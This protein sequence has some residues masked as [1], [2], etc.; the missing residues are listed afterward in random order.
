MISFVARRPIAFSI[1]AVLSPLIAIKLLDAWLTSLA[2][3]D[4]GNRLVVE[5]LFC[6]YVTFLLSRLHWWHDAGFR[7]P[8]VRSRLLAYLPLLFLPLIVLAGAGIKPASGNRIIGFAIFTLM[9]GFA[10]EGL[11][12]GVVL[13]ALL[14][15][16]AMRAALISSLIFG[17]GHLANIWQGASPSATV[18]QVIFST[19]LGIGFAGARL[20][21]GTI[22]PAI[23]LHFLMDLFDVAGRGFALPGPQAVTPSRAL[24][25]ISLTGIC[26]LYGWWLMRRTRSVEE[27]G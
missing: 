27:I 16:G 3:P 7:R 12:R 21:S 13:Q 23:G 22:W 11:L 2:L 18:V 20:Y 4:L 25:P 15:Q 9:V 6:C 24:I 1:V 26:A 5:A 10:E 14:P 8:A 19:F 17:A